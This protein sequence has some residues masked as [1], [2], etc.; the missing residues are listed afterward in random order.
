MTPGQI[1]PGVYPKELV[2]VRRLKR[3]YFCPFLAPDLN[4]VGQIVLP[5]PVIR[6]YPFQSTEEKGSFD[7][8]DARV[9]LVDSPFKRRGI[10]LF[11]DPFHLFPLPS[12]HPSVSCGIGQSGGGNR[13]G[14]PFLT[15]K[16]N[17]FREGFILD[18]GDIPVENQ[19]GP[20]I[21]AKHV[22]GAHDRMAAPQLRVLRNKDQPVFREGLL[23]T[24]A[25]I[26]NDNNGFF[27]PQRVQGNLDGVAQH[28]LSHDGMEYLDQ[29]RFHPR[30]LT[31]GKNDCCQSF[32][33]FSR[34][35]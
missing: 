4:N 7:T 8:V 26:A 9:N 27:S 34:T 16:G 25:L 3:A 35:I 15:V 5:L 14:G 29:A 10:F 21:A 19:D 30:S 28:G 32:H 18:Q 13:E 17:E 1:D 24:V 6:L 22:L 12:D 2:R 23:D 31:R 20:I 11:H 33:G